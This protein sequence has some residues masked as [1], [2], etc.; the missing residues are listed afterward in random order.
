MPMKTHIPIEVIKLEDASYHIMVKARF[1]KKVQGNLIIDTGASKTVFDQSLG[2][3]LKVK[4]EE[5]PD[6]DSSGINAIIPHAFQGEI[7]RFQIGELKLKN[8]ISVFL[9]LSHIN[10]L[11]EKYTNTQITG[12]L[13]SDFLVSHKA[14][15]DYTHKKLTLSYKKR[16]S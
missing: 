16:G 6:Q 14:V 9:D 7:E 10:Q 3:K 13:G 12:L 4:M 5:V 1:G 8:I 15:I 11:Y 2:T